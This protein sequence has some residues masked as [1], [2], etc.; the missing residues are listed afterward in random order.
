[1][2]KTLIAGE[3]ENPWVEYWNSENVWANSNLWSKQMRTFV[4]LSSELMGFSR[5]DKVLD[6]GCGNGHFA[7]IA[8]G[9]LGSVVCADVSEH[10]IEVCKRKFA[11]TSNVTVARIKPDMSDISTLGTGFTKVICFSVLH[12]FSDLDYVRGFVRGMQQICVSGA[13]MIIGDI[14]SKH[15]TFKDNL[16]ALAF[17]LREGMLIDAVSVVTR[18]WLNDSRYRKIK[19]RG[20]SYLD[21]PERYVESLGLDL[22][23]KVTTIETQFTVN[24]NY[25][26]VLIEF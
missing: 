18:I 8:A 11:S 23:L 20:N 12:Y 13:K 4:R 19:Q 17:V 6:F 7:E 22:G 9:R 14:G 10:Y 3:P 26:N 5:D 1:M 15:R 24:A 2:S 16:K 25:Q 21:V